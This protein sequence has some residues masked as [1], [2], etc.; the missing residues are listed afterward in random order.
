[1]AGI[2]SKDVVTTVEAHDSNVDVV[3]FSDEEEEVVEQF[4]RYD[5]HG[6]PHV[7]RCLVDALPREVVY[8]K[9]WPMLMCSGNALENFRVCSEI[10]MVCR[11]WLRFVDGTKEW[12]DGMAAWHNRPRH[13]GDESDDAHID[14]DYDSSDIEDDGM[15]Y[16]FEYVMKPDGT[17]TVTRVEH[18]TNED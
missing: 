17:F 18:N 4:Y 11:G 13:T 5:P 9:L 6:E 7:E 16:G 14:S 3:Q 15:L 8:F 12:A 10:R 2:D 1:M